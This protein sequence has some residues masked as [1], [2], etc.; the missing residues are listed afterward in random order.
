MTASQSPTSGQRAPPSSSAHLDQL[1]DFLPP[2]PDKD[3]LITW[4][5]ARKHLP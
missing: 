4:T 5:E 3:R 1:L 2:G